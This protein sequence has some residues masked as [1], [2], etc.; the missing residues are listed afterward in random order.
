[1]NETELDS[2][3][4]PALDVGDLAV[5]NVAVAGYGDDD[6]PSGPRDVVV[7]SVHRRD[8]RSPTPGRVHAYGVM[9]RPDPETRTRPS[10]EEEAW[11]DASLV[12]PDEPIGVRAAYLA[13]LGALRSMRSWL[14]ADIDEE[15]ERVEREL[16]KGDT[17]AA[18]AP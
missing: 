13:R 12:F 2:A 15:I 9:S 17:D 10:R 5:A 11:A 18:S 7:T 8:H 4:R 14:V 3:G 16:A 1:M 6:R